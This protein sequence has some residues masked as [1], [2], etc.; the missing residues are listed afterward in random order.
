MRMPEAE[1]SLRDSFTLK[2]LTAGGACATTIWVGANTRENSPTPFICHGLLPWR[3]H[4]HSAVNTQLHQRLRVQALMVALHP[5]PVV[6]GLP[7][8]S[9]VRGQRTLSRNLD[10]AG[11]QRTQQPLGRHSPAAVPPTM[12]PQGRLLTRTWAYPRHPAP[13]ECWA[14]Q[15]DE[16]REVTAVKPQG[17]RLQETVGA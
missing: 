4:E 17:W 9:Q 10:P 12:T 15:G 11:A 7:P 2:S 5:A 6:V 13:Q 1:H 3:L 14:Q 8:C 16:Y